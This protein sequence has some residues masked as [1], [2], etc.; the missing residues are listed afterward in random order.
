VESGRWQVLLVDANGALAERI[1]ALF[2]DPLLSGYALEQA[3]TLGEALASLDAGRHDAYLVAEHVGPADGLDLVREA[4]RRGVPAPLFVLAA[5]AERDR[6]LAAL[7]AGAADYLPAVRTD[8]ATLE[9][10]L[11][12]GLAR[13][14]TSKALQGQLRALERSAAQNLVLAEMASLL[15]TCQGTEQACA[16][17]TACA[18]RLFPV[19][20][21]AVLLLRDGA[22]ELTPVSVWGEPRLRPGSCAALA[23]ESFPNPTLVRFACAH[24]GGPLP[25]ASLCVPL[26]AQ[27]E[28]MGVLHVQATGPGSDLAAGEVGRQ[29]EGHERLAQLVADQA[30][31]AVASLRRRQSL[32][33]QAIRDPLT[34]LFNR[35]HMEESL[36]REVRRAQRRQRPLGIILLDLDHFKRTNDTHGHEAGDA[37]LRTVGHFLQTHIRGEDLACR[38]GGEEFLLILT[39]SS[40]ED[41]RR[42]AEDLREGIKALQVLHGG[43]PLGPVSASLGVAVFPEHG[44]TAEAV[45]RAA[46]TALYQAKA[47]GRDRVSVGP[48]LPLAGPHS[49][50]F[51][52]G[53]ALRKP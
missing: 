52:T 20:A 31:L 12:Y 48:A 32:R 39:D 16:V 33:E 28:A 3:T 41:T 36:E 35:R 17:V 23:P 40:L 44:A 50:R 6:D 46:D 42:R 7:A 14:R 26:V 5:K 8:A 9:R 38:Y 24:L 22:A 34:N 1:R 15:L 19:E 13:R 37:L 21:G 2:I 51:V 49:G 18:A 11:R 53:A 43:R 25:A 27:G 10:A 29:P 47:D 30:A 4:R 45:V